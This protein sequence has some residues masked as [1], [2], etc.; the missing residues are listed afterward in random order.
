M[1]GILADKHGNA[2]ALE[3]VLVDAERRGVTEFVDLGDVLYGPL[4]PRRTFEL[5]KKVN[6]IAH[7]RGNQDR[8]IL[9]GPRNPTLDWVRSDLGREPL[10][11][12]DGLPLTAK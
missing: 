8:L 6:I 11:W 9:E 1:L 7:V 5:L 10:P 12:L 2:W 3:A 4:A